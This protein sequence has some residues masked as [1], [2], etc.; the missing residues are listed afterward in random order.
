M[1]DC[2]NTVSAYCAKAETDYKTSVIAFKKLDSSSADFSSVMSKYLQKDVHNQK[3]DNGAVNL[4]VSP[5]SKAL[6]KFD[7]VAQGAVVGQ[8]SM[9]EA[10][11]ALKEAKLC[12]ELMSEVRKHLV[13]GFNQI[14]NNS[15]G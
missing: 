4:I 2:I 9:L 11:R 12:L 7:R 5:L 6:S 1:I 3:L 14:L 10:A 13:S 15:S 8:F